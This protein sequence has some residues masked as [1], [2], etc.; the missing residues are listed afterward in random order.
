VWDKPAD[1]VQQLGEPQFG[2][3]LR[4]FV[5]EFTYLDQDV[6]AGVRSAI[7]THLH[8]WRSQVHDGIKQFLLALSSSQR[9]DLA[10]ALGLDLSAK[11]VRFEVRSLQF[12]RKASPTCVSSPQV[13]ISIV[14]E[15]KEQ[16]N[17]QSFMFSGGCTIVIDPRS[18]E[19]QYVI[20]KNINS[21]S[22]LE[23]ERAFHLNSRVG[24]VGLYLGAVNETYPSRQLANLHGFETEINY[25]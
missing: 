4:P 8:D 11:D 5:D 17:D 22:R 6:S 9:N 21:A 16:L 3:R 2:K 10:A 24:L 25:G 18:G 23:E 7:F 15:R 1:I 20:C 14:Q 12:A 19:V 13:L